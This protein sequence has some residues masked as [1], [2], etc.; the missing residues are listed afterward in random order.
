MQMGA[1][2]LIADTVFFLWM[3]DVVCRASKKLKLYR[4]INVML[5]FINLAEGTLL[6]HEL[7]EYL[8]FYILH[9]FEA[10]RVIGNV[11]LAGG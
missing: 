11:I 7:L 3:V 8:T 6:F 4:E 9:Q 10:V 1:F 2:W 5:M